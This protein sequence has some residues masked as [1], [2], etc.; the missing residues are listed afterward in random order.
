MNN[1]LSFTDPTGL[2]T[3]CDNNGNCYTVVWGNGFDWWGGWSVGGSVGGGFVPP[4]GPGAGGGNGAANN[5]KSAQLAQQ[6]SFNTQQLRQKW[7]L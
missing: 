4:N 5:G 7:G 1:P 2:K 3:V 6:A